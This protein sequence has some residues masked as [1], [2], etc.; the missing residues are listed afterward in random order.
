MTHIHYSLAHFQNTEHLITQ[1][2]TQPHSLA[3]YSQQLRNNI[4]VL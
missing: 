1:I 4:K 3:L 2:L